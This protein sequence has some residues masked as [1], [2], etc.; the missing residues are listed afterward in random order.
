M[1]SECHHDAHSLHDQRGDRSGVARETKVPYNARTGKTAKSNDPNTW[2]SFEEALA[3]EMLA[4]LGADAPM[5][6]TR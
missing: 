5:E 1:R 4:Q 2:S 6:A 3:W